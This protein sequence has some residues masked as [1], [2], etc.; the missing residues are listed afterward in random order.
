MILTKTVVFA[1]VLAVCTADCGDRENMLACTQDGAC[2]WN[3]LEG[4][5]NE[6][7]DGVVKEIKVLENPSGKPSKFSQDG[8]QAYFDGD[9][10]EGSSGDEMTALGAGYAADENNC[11]YKTKLLGTGDKCKKIKVLELPSGKLSKWA[12][13]KK[14]V[15]YAG[16]S[17]TRASMA[18]IEGAEVEFLKDGYVKIG[19]DMYRKGERTP[20]RKLLSKN[21]ASSSS[22][23]KKTKKKKTKSVKCSR[24]SKWEKRSE[25]A[26]RGCKYDMRNPDDADACHDGESDGWFRV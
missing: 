21:S 24:W 25:C 13:S 7:G 8:E 15:W 9:K 11:F 4:N 26:A 14:R 10:V 3:A 20:P 12:V 6:G 16:K 19:E 23:K 1:L 18:I 17:I 5:C 22:K 2:T